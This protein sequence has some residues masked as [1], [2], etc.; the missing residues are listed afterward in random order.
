[1]RMWPRTNPAASRRSR[2][3]ARG[4]TWISAGLLVLPLL[5]RSPTAYLHRVRN[6]VTIRFRAFSSEHDAHLDERAPIASADEVAVLMRRSGHVLSAGEMIAGTFVAAGYGRDALAADLLAVLR[7]YEARQHG[8]LRGVLR[9]LG[10]VCRNLPYVVPGYGRAEIRA[11]RYCPEPSTASEETTLDRFGETLARHA[12]T[13][14]HNPTV[15]TPAARTVLT[16]RVTGL[17]G[18][19]CADIPCRIE[20]QVERLQSY[21]TTETIPPATARVMTGYGTITITLILAALLTPW[22][23]IANKATLSGVAAFVPS[24]SML[25]IGTSTLCAI[26]AHTVLN[27][28]NEETMATIKTIAKSTTII[29]A[30]STLLLGAGLSVDNQGGIGVAAGLILYLLILLSTLAADN[31]VLRSEVRLKQVTLPSR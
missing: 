6:V 27:R 4:A 3:R 10:A 23:G 20:E 19:S 16:T 29:L 31:L 8:I 18:D 11:A 2:V 9:I 7:F 21:L 14:V 12:T 13:L 15:I 22:T 28:L 25:F 1:M 24:L 30:I 26:I 17:D 5:R